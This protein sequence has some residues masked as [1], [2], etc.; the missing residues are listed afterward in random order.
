MLGCID[1]RGIGCSI[2]IAGARVSC[3]L[4]TGGRS[5]GYIRID[6]VNIYI[7]I[8]LICHS[9]ILLSPNKMIPDETCFDC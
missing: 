1:T 7:Y 5:Q 8:Y 3:V 6:K 9:T 2:F 4:Y